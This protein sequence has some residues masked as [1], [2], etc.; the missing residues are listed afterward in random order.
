MRTDLWIIECRKPDGTLDFAVPQP[1][2]VFGNA[3]ISGMDDHA[4]AVV[5]FR[6]LPD[7][8]LEGHMI[9]TWPSLLDARWRARQKTW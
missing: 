8:V 5:I 3:A 7:A 4:M 1:E 2:S 9:A 6:K